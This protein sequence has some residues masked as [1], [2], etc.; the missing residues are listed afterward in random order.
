MNAIPRVVLDVNL[1]VV[2]DL[3]PPVL[4]IVRLLLPLR[5]D[6]G[7]RPQREATRV[8]DLA[9]LLVLLH[10]R[11]W[12]PVDKPVERVCVADP[13]GEEVGVVRGDGRGTEVPAGYVLEH[14]NLQD[15]WVHAVS[16]PADHRRLS[17]VASLRCRCIHPCA[18]STPQRKCPEVAPPSRI[19]PPEP[20]RRAHLEWRV[21]QAVTKQ[22]APK[23]LGLL[24]GAI[25]R[26]TKPKSR[27]VIVVA[28]RRRQTCQRIPGIAPL[29]D[30][31]TR[32]RPSSRLPNAGSP[33]SLP[34]VTT[35]RRSPS[36]RLWGIT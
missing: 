3:R 25:L 32:A 29:E 28:A 4:G 2:V 10:L 21:V 34:L 16:P 13:S 27:I 11:C 14:V 7:R 8:E 23:R 22:H 36:S 5:Q 12:E 19:T 24:L 15:V 17:K 26:S 35:G 31:T 18:A 9:R 1:V 20:K 6:R 30:V 33:R